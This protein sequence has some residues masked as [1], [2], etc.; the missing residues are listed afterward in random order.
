[1][2]LGS[3]PNPLAPL[4]RRWGVGRGSG[5]VATPCPAP[6]SQYPHRQLLEN[7]YNVSFRAYNRTLQF[8]LQWKCGP[9][10]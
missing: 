10:L 6:A 1:M 7:M 4:R 8:R 3:F 9:G 5:R 2:P